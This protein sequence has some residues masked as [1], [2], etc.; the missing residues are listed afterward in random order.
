MSLQNGSHDQAVD[1]LL[2]ALGQTT[3]P[4]GME[5][6]ILRRLAVRPEANGLRFGLWPS[7]LTAV[8]AAVL[9]TLF[10]DAKAVGP[11]GE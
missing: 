3:P 10:V 7:L 9:L 5:D 6:R 11:A 1:K 8:A 2:A 4:A